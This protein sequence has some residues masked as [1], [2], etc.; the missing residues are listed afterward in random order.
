MTSAGLPGPDPAA[1]TVFEA[2]LR[3]GAP[4]QPLGAVHDAWRW[5]DAAAA[6]FS[7]GLE[8]Q[9]ALWQPWWVAQA[10]WLKQCRA[11]WPVELPATRGEE[12]LA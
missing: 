12:Q 8:L 10:L 6:A 5:I 9:Q 1:P 11:A 3:S 4:W 2:W 7:A